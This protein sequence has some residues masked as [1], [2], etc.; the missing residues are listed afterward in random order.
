MKRVRKNTT[1]YLIDGYIPKLQLVVHEY[2]QAHSEA[3]AWKDI[4][5]RL[6]NGHCTVVIP[7]NLS[8]Y[9]NIIKNPPSEKTPITTN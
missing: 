4:Y 3:E 6:Y 9:C 8:D 5:R 1:P 7:P 2:T